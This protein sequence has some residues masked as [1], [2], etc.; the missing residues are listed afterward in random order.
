MK[1][2]PN[3]TPNCSPLIE[4]GC[5]LDHESSVPTQVCQMQQVQRRGCDLP[6]GRKGKAILPWASRAPL[7]QPACCST[8]SPCVCSNGSFLSDSEKI[9][10]TPSVCLM[11]WGM[12]RWIT[13]VGCS[14]LISGFPRSR[15]FKKSCMQL[16]LWACRVGR[17]LTWK[18]K[19]VSHRGH[20][21]A[22]CHCGWSLV[23]KGD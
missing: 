22:L 21:Q 19:G 11:L 2:P 13:H 18:R 1:G 8:I 10:Q 7:P 14:Y 23:P 3:T 15:Y 16:S 12:W 5:Q 4:E 9:Y 20:H 17:G 6:D